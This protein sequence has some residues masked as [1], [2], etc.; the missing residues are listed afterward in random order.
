MPFRETAVINPSVAVPVKW[1]GLIHAATEN[2]WSVRITGPEVTAA[3]VPS[4][5]ASYDECW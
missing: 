5:T 2:D 1:V 3:L 4:N